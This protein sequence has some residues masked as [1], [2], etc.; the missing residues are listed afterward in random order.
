MEINAV[1]LAAGLSS[2]MEAFKPLL[3][4]KG[5]TMIEHCIDCMLEAGVNQTVVVLG[6]RAKDIEEL[7]RKN[8]ECNR[9]ILVHNQRYMETDMLTSVKVGI[10]ALQD[11]DGFYILPGDMPAICTSTFLALEVAMRKTNA[12]VTFPEVD[13]HRTHP[14]LIS[15]KCKDL[16]LRFEGDGGLREMWKQLENQIIT[17]PVNDSGCLMDADTR[18]DYD[19]LKHY[20]EESL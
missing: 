14:P 16:I 6:Y 20:M 9:V 17:V 4:L 5:K 18:E 1:I 7:L 11:C 15:W 10:S 2:R 19:R 12:M 8:Y 13:G 3:E